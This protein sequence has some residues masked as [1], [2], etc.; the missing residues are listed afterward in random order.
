MRSIWIY[1]MGLM[2]VADAALAAPQADVSTLISGK[3]H[4]AFF[5]V[6]IDGATGIAVGAGGAVYN[7]TDSGKT[8]KPE[9]STTEL[10]LLGVDSK[11]KA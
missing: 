7:S 4:D 5:S 10:S 9:A 11:V 8:W 2:C 3:P 1:A 6:A